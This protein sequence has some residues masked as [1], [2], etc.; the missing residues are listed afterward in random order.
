MNARV[1]RA[2]AVLLVALGMVLVNPNVA[3]ACSCL[4]RTVAQRTQAA[5]TVAIGTVNW[6]ATD[7]EQ[8]SYSVTFSNVYKGIAGMQEKLTTPDSEAACGVGQ[9]AANDDYLFFIQGKHPGLMPI[10]ACGG[11]ERP[12]A[13]TLDAVQRITGAPNP[14]FPSFG[15]GPTVSA[16]ST[17]PIR[18]AGIAGL[19]LAALFVVVVLVRRRSQGAGPRQYLG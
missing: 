14:P 11:V 13:A 19:I 16:S 15:S 10:N 17:D 9:L 12:T 8:R 5:E 4:N 6:S 1:A 7:G 2:L 18:V 3:L